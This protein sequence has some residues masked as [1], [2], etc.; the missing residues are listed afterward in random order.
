MLKNDTDH[1]SLTGA[2]AKINVSGQQYRWLAGGY[3][4]DIRHF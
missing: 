2:R 1:L 3:D 4:L